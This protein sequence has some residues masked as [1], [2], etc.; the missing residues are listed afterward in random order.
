M[1]EAESQ[2]VLKTVTGQDF[3]D[4]LKKWQKRWE[5]CIHAEGDY[6]RVM[7]ASRPKDTF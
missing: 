1:I 5:I 4:A 3:Q 6:S 7:L 2:A